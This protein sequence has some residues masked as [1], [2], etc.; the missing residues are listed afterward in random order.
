MHLVLRPLALVF[1]GA[2]LLAS[3][4]AQDPA[5]EP[6]GGS[7]VI[8]GERFEVERAEIA[9]RRELAARLDP[10][11]PPSRLRAL[12]WARAIA[13]RGAE[14]RGLEVDPEAF[15]RW[16]IDQH[17][18][19]ADAWTTDGAL[20]RAKLQ[21]FV[22]AIGFASVADYEAFQRERYL[23]QLF[24]ESEIPRPE[25]DEAAIRERFTANAS[26]YRIT[27]LVFA[28]ETVGPDDEVDRENPVAVD[29]YRRWY[30]R[31]DE[32]QRR[33]FDD[34]DHPA[35]AADVLYVRFDDKSPDELQAWLESRRRADGRTIAEVVADWE[36]EPLDRAKIFSRWVNERRRVL[37]RL[38]ALV[39]LG[40]DDQASFEAVEDAMLREWRVIRYVAEVW[41][42]L[43]ERTEPIDMEA[44]S[45]RTGLPLRRIPLTPFHQLVNDVELRG[46]A[47]YP[48]RRLEPGEIL[49]YTANT[50]VPASIYYFGGPVEQPGFHVS[51]W[52]LRRFEDMRARP[53]EEV[54]DRA[55]PVFLRSRAWTIA[56]RSLAAFGDA[57]R[58]AMTA[59]IGEL[60]KPTPEDLA[61]IR[62]E[63]FPTMA[64][65]AENAEILTPIFV[66]PERASDAAGGDAILGLRVQRFLESQWR[67]L[68]ALSDTGL[69]AGE[70]I[71]LMTDRDRYVGVLPRIDEVIPPRPGRFEAD[72]VARRAAEAELRA[73]MEELWAQ[74]VEE[75]WAWERMSERYAL[76]LE[77]E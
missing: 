28:P 42:E 8:D 21:R 34:R 54:I 18:H 72:V 1:V 19:A 7:F 67:R 45:V 50:Q 36:P 74:Q 16:M 77:A 12:A 11:L 60:E 70:V 31:L 40:A 76:E 33:L 30:A 26:V 17:A 51:I 59:E 48:M 75:A 32:Q 41:K 22:E 9:R 46:D 64:E 24:V 14:S 68:R 43:D 44:E 56:Q 39:P 13:A 55:W 25:P 2:A 53:A 10:A 23:A 62:R 63:L 29:E 66:R 37:A 27:A 47:V 57:W 52:Q 58:K 5:A 61:R 69:V 73:E 49:D 4:S 15:E 3:A 20:D 38:N 65:E 35:L 6:R 71:A